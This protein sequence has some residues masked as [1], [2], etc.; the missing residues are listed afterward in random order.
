MSLCTTCNKLC[1]SK[2]TA[3]YF[4]SHIFFCNVTLPLSRHYVESILFPLPQIWV[5]PETALINR[6]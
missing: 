2:I 3:K 5:D 6:L 4:P 1:S